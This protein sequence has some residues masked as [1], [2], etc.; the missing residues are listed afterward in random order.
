MQIAS[1]IFLLALLPWVALLL[2]LLLGRRRR[3]NV[4]FLEFWKGPVTG[5]TARRRIGMPPLALAVALAALLLMIL[6]AARPGIRSAASTDDVPVVVVV[7]RGISMSMGRPPRF[8]ALLDEMKPVIREQFAAGAPRIAFVPGGEATSIAPTAIDT[9]GILDLAV[10][11]QL[12]INSGSPVIVLTDQQLHISD[13]RLVRVSP[14]SELKNISIAHI[15]ARISPASQVMVRVRNQSDQKQ[16]IIRLLSDEHENARQE[17]ELPATG[18]VRE[19]FLPFDPRAK[20]VRVEIDAADDFAA[21]NSAFLVRRGSW[22]ILEPRTP[23]FA[24]LARLVEKYSKLRPP[25]DESKRIAIVSA[26]DA[27]ADPQI[28]FG[29]LGSPATGEATVADHPL[30]KSLEKVDWQQLAADGIAEP[31]GDGWK[32]LVGVGGK[33]AIAVRE[34]PARQVWMGLKTQPIANTP[35]F[36][37]LWSNIFDWVGEGGEEFVAQPT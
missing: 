9:T 33:A 8:A 31:A 1:P 37:I 29:N 16:A 24:E 27:G 13:D 20:V 34:A 23:L 15:A 11:Q 4:S 2:W 12:E 35:E 28:I 7:D 22:P 32:S 14:Q 21:D 3:V 26:Q 25:G 36:V 18:Q 5:P 6:A 30:T 19:Y 17:A 10:R